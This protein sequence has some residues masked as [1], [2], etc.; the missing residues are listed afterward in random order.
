M[1]YA[2]EF[3]DFNRYEI[4]DFKNLQNPIPCDTGCPSTIL[5]GR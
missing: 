1:N 4:L 5:V 2:N 3:N